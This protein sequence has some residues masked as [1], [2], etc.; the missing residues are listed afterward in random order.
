MG[1][2]QTVTVGPSGVDTIEAYAVGEKTLA[3]RLYPRL[4]ADEL[5]TADRRFYSWAGWDTATG[6]AL[7]WRAPTGLTLPVVKSGRNV[8]I[9][10]P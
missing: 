1:P 6:D 9:L 5:L 10:W 7:L 2:D 8:K 3:Q 4:R